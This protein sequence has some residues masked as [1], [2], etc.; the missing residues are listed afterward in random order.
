MTTSLCCSY[1]LL[2]IFHGPG[3]M[4]SPTHMHYLTELS[5]NLARQLESSPYYKKK[6]LRLKEVS[7]FFMVIHL[8]HDGN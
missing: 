4:L 2:S 8:V 1:D 5:Q 6:K 3:P 7:N